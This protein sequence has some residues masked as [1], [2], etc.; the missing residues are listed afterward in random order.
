M[1]SDYKTPV[2]YQY[3]L[4]VERQLAK[5]LALEIGYVGS[6]G[7]HLGVRYN[8]NLPVCVT[9]PCTATNQFVRPYPTFGDIQYQNQ[10]A[11]SSYNALQMSVRRRLTGG[12][13]LLAS[14]TFSRALDNASSTNNST[15]G[16]QKFPQDPNRL[17]LE[18]GLSDFHRAH[19]FSASFNYELPIGRNRKFLSNATGLT[20]TL[21]AGWQ[22]NGIVTVL[23]GRPFTPQY[24]SNA[25]NS[26]NQRPDI[27]GDPFANVPAGLYFNPN[28]F[29]MPVATAGD[30]NLFGNL[31][32]NTLIG[33]GFAD[34]DFSLLKNIK[35][36]EGLKLQFRG[37]VFN[38]LNHPN[39]HVPEYRLD[40]PNVGRFTEAEEGR[41]FQFAVKLLF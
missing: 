7:R 35:I 22:V 1:E 39:F 18:K 4:T 17:D 14:Y 3:N 28:A 5:D 20:D 26:G 25:S 41:E 40:L 31:G 16:T 2:F 6:Q 36:T 24:N 10:I 27:I 34:M 30:T 13:T 15:S 23:S 8:P 37:E 21:A 9:A 11:N 12:M 33:P 19:Q 38:V 32:R 29:A